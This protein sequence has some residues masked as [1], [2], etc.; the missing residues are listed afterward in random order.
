MNISKA[1]VSITKAA[2]LVGI[3]YGVLNWQDINLTDDG[4][5]DFAEKAC[6]SE[7]T[8]RFNVTTVK[9]YA[10]NENSNGFVVRAT[11]TLANGNTARVN[12]LTNVH[13]GVRDI[14]IEE[15]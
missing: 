13:G 10:I 11:V 8:Q 1:I 12:C 15:R 7:I 6:I 5:K 14:M 9:A 4:V 3:A 2:V